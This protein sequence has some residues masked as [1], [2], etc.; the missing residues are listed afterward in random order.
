MKELNNI[1]D[2]EMTGLP[3]FRCMELDIGNEHLEF[4]CR[5][6]LECIKMLFGDPDFLK[7][8]ALSPIQYYTNAEH[9]SRI[10]NEMHSADWWWSTQVRNLNYNEDENLL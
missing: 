8:L 6:T 9:T 2:N 10:I 3:S 4:H 1:I 5:D 7:D